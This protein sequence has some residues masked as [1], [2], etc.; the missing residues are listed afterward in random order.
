MMITRWE[1]GRE[2]E[3]AIA[4]MV[5]VVVVTIIICAT[6]LIYA[7]MDNFFAGRISNFDAR[8]IRKELERLS[9]LIE[10]LKNQKQ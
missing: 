8:E 10:E 9:N 3:K 7:Y 4:V 6:V 5:L 1:G 2:M